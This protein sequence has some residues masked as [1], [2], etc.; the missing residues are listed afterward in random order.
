M[1]KSF[2]WLVIATALFGVGCATTPTIP[3]LA[4]ATPARSAE[5][6]AEAV[7]L[8]Y[9][10][11][12]E[13]LALSL[14][15]QG[16]DPSYARLQQVKNFRE[17][18]VRWAELD[19]NIYRALEGGYTGGAWITVV[20]PGHEVLKRMVATLQVESNPTLTVLLVKPEMITE[21]WAGIILVHELSHLMDRLYQVEPMNPTREQFLEGELRAYEAEILAA[22][23]LTRG[24][25][26][27]QMDML[28]AQWRPASHEELI[29]RVRAIDPADWD[30][31]ETTMASAV[32]ES[33]AE[34]SLRGGFY[35]IALSI[36]FAG[37]Q[38][39]GKKAALAA[40]DYLYSRYE[41]TR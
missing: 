2:A 34:Q 33:M 21:R 13:R 12:F 29:D 7:R 31:L 3:T 30:K 9:N 26:E 32:P 28:L 4:T 19:G 1:R 6:I 22:S 38:P 15:E 35:V 20:P 18:W 36:R 14:A 27:R 17:R 24:A 16:H 40:I 8:S 41:L 11:G 10:R 23:L 25:L 37:T 39:D 5:E